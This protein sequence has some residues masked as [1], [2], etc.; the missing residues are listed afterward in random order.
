LPD[1]SPDPII[2]FGPAKVIGPRWNAPKQTKAGPMPAD[3]GL[4]LNKD[5]G[6][7]PCRPKPAQKNPKHPIFDCQPRPRI[8]SIKNAQLL[9]QSKDLNA[10][11]IA[12]T[13]ERTKKSEKSNAKWNHSPGFI[14]LE[15]APALAPNT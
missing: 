2:D 4:R 15:T 5:E 12:G 14:S 11:I 10:Q 6:M 7:G 1:S 9:A 3:Y 13:E 8:L